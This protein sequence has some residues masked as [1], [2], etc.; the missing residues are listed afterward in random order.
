M[1]TPTQTFISQPSRSSAMFLLTQGYG[2]LM[3][4]TM[5][6]VGEGDQELN[7]TYREQ[8]VASATGRCRCVGGAWCS[9]SGPHRH[10][11]TLLWCVHHRQFAG[12][13]G[14]VSCRHCAV[15]PITARRYRLVSRA[16]NAH[17]GRPKMCICRCLR[18]RMPVKINEP[19]LM[20]HGEK[21]SNSGTYPMQRSACMKR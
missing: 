20:I 18:L 13:F 7:D 5:P 16:S 1:T 8:L 17:F 21:D 6:I 15:V 11:W 2:V 12:T 19:M 14:P 10:W 4:P 3:G 9:R